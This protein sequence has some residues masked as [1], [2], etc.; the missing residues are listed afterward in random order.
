MFNLNQLLERC[1]RPIE[2][3]DTLIFF[4]LYYLKH[5]NQYRY[6]K[7]L[8]ITFRLDK[9]TKDNSKSVSE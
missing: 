6:V 1:Y 7:I 9:L 2:Y 4:Y 5:K 3:G 8:D